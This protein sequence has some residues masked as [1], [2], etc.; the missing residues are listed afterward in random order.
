MEAEIRHALGDGA[1]HFD[2]MGF[3][4]AICPK[5]QPAD[6]DDQGGGNPGK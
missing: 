3:K 2:A 5:Q 6:Y 4:P 1:E